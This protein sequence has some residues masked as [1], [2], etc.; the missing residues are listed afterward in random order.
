LSN[1]Q[2]VLEGIRAGSRLPFLKKTEIFDN[3]LKFANGMYDLGITME[4]RWVPSHSGVEGNERVDEL[5]KRFRRSGQ[6]IL[7]PHSSLPILSNITVMAGSLDSL[8]QALLEIKPQITHGTEGNGDTAEMEASVVFQE[9]T[10]R[11]CSPP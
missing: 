10:D 11:A 2:N 6:A 3:F 1:F 4:L 5:V 7:A 8:R 9:L